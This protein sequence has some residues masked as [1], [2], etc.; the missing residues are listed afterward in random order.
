MNPWSFEVLDMRAAPYAAAPEL[1]ARLRVTEGTGTPVH[2]IALHC[3]V[4]IEPQRRGYDAQ[5]EAGLRAL[6]DQRSRW[7]ETLRPFQWMQCDTTVQGFRDKTEVDL[8]L[9]CTYDFDVTGS[10]YLHAVGGGSVPLSLL[11]SGTAFLRGQDG[12]AV[13][14]IP[15][16]CEARY[17]LPVAVWRQ[18]IA[19]YF[20]G[21]GWIRMDHDVVAAL[22]AYRARQGLTSW[23]EAV[24]RLL[25]DVSVLDGTP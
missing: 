23:D 4:R 5:D 14:Q 12:F 19:T 11:F 8:P 2:A 25:A 10:R 22:A 6:F 17:E 18:M 13:Q 16:D 7:S 20:P 15:W 9:P 3:Q 1:T 24:T 21:T